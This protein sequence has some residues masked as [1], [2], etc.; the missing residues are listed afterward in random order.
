MVWKKAIAAALTIVGAMSLQPSY[1]ARREVLIRASNLRWKSTVQEQR[2]L[3]ATATGRTTMPD[4]VDGL[5]KAALGGDRELAPGCS[6]FA[7]WL[8]AGIFLEGGADIL[9]TPN[10][11]GRDEEIFNGAGC[12]LAHHLSCEY[13]RYA[14][15]EAV[16]THMQGAAPMCDRVR[17]LVTTDLANGGGA[18]LTQLAQDHP[19]LNFGDPIWPLMIGAI[20][21]WQYYKTTR[22]SHAGEIPQGYAWQYPGERREGCHCYIQPI[23]LNETQSKTVAKTPYL[24]PE[25]IGGMLYLNDVHV[26]DRVMAQ[27][28]RMIIL[29]F[30]CMLEHWRI[31]YRDG[32]W[33]VA[34]A[35]VILG[36]DHNT[37]RFS[38]ML[39]ALRLFGYSGPISGSIDG[40]P[41]GLVPVLEKARAK[42]ASYYRDALQAHPIW[43]WGR[44]ESS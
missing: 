12:A 23:F 40:S 26:D 3:F 43:W 4:F 42:S 25:T 5:S 33:E 39:R 11:S 31:E 9:V 10:C 24:T 32:R 17:H 14:F 36:N 7:V 41:N 34:N 30:A 18:A 27:A 28:L 29:N 37:K 22:N 1:A 19:D 15:I 20:T 8:L 13:V 35:R 21:P 2:F 44:E 16:T 38:R 6:M